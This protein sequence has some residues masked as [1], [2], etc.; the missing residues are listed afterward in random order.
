MAAKLYGLAVDFRQRPAAEAMKLDLNLTRVTVIDEGRHNQD[1]CCLV[2]P[3]HVNRKLGTPRGKAAPRT[4]D[5]LRLTFEINPLSKAADSVL[6]LRAE[7]LE[8]CYLPTLIER[9]GLF[10]SPPPDLLVLNDLSEVAINSAMALQ[11]NTATGL[12]YAIETHK[13]I[14]LDIRLGAPTILVPSKAALLAVDLGTLSIKSDLS[15]QG[16]VGFVFRFSKGKVAP[17]L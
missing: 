2:R 9:L 6:M 14:D 4:N 17:P 7:P 8:V 11:T 3:R 15:T 1:F 13:T 5:L 10:F 12:L 16:K